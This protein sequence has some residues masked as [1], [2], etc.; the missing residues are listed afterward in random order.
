MIRSIQPVNCSAIAFAILALFASAETSSDARGARTCSKPSGYVLAHSDRGR[1]YE[2]MPGRRVCGQLRGHGAHDFGA[3]Y[4]EG[5]GMRRFR[6]AGRWG[7][8]IMIVSDAKSSN[9]GYQAPRRLNLRTGQYAE[10]RGGGFSGEGIK[11]DALAVNTAGS[12]AWT[13]YVYETGVTEVWVAR[14]GAK[15]RRVAADRRVYRYY[16]AVDATS[17]H[18]RL[19]GADQQASIV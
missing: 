13:A 7:A 17:V 2:A 11:L 4:G 12:I 1:L 14:A 6:V 5:V 18:W 16:V 19:G 8:A 9:P 10:L 3:R 15:P